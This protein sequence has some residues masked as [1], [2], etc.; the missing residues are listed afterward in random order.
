[1]PI[2][3]LALDAH[4]SHGEHGLHDGHHH[5][6]H[7]SFD[8]TA[9]AGASVSCSLENAAC[10]HQK[11]QVQ[12]YNAQVRAAMELETGIPSTAAQ[13]AKDDELNY[14]RELH[15]NPE[16][17]A[18][19]YK[20][21]AQDS[22]EQA[23][24][25]PGVLKKEFLMIRAPNA[26]GS[27]SPIWEFDANKANHPL[28]DQAATG[29]TGP[30]F[31][32]QNHATPKFIQVLTNVATVTVGVESPSDGPN[33]L[34]SVVVGGLPKHFFHDEDGHIVADKYFK[35]LVP[36]ILQAK[37]TAPGNPQFTDAD[38]TLF[39]GGDDDG[40]VQYLISCDKDGVP[41]LLNVTTDA[42]VP[43]YAPTQSTVSEGPGAIPVM[44]TC[45]KVNTTGQAMSDAINVDANH[46]FNYQNTG[47]TLFPGQSFT[48]ATDMIKTRYGTTDW[49]NNGKYLVAM[50]L[51]AG[52]E[53]E[54]AWHKEHPLL[55]DLAD[56]GAIPIGRTFL[57]GTISVD[58]IM[59]AEKYGKPALKKLIQE[60]HGWF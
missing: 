27:P 42:E 37:Q 4:H 8:T 13:L 26:E 36:D 15:P 18:K 45:V 46:L 30:G 17:Q 6:A 35:S 11:A 29:Y 60:P 31:R 55:S 2:H 22:I 49:P 43:P 5:V 10:C 7:T 12:Q 53:D 54:A 47:T 34:Q 25:V 24:A 40:H 39:K 38:K 33:K 41:I 48:S 9:S 58:E 21:L 50:A 1:M 32:I 59:K 14:Q 3:L 19:S 56:E 20:E 28:L 51:P 16:E 57:N 52:A 23:A 44:A